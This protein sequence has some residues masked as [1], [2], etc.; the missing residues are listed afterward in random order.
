MTEIAQHD[1]PHQE[2]LS[3]DA[4]QDVIDLCLW[5]G[6]LLLQHGANSSRTEE[7][8][9]HFGTGLGLNWLDV[10]VMANAL[11]ITAVTE[12][13]FRTKTR[14]I[15]RFGGVNMAMV[16]AVSDLSHRVSAGELDRVAVRQ[17]LSQIDKQPRRYANWL[18]IVV[19]GL[20]CAA[21]SRLF[22]A[23]WITFGVTWVAAS[24]GTAVRQWLLRQHFNYMVQVLLAAFVAGS[25]ASIGT[26]QGWEAQ[27]QIALAACVLFLIPGVPL[28]NAFHDLISS[29]FITGIARGVFGGLI[30]LGIAVGL[31]LALTL[32]GITDLWAAFTPPATLWSD[33]LWA[34]MAA[35]GFAILFNLP[36]SALPGAV[37]CGAIGHGMRYV[38]LASGWRGVSNIEMASLLGATAVG[39]LGLVLARRRQMPRITFTVPGIIPMIPGTFA[40]G[41][42]LNVLQAAGIIHLTT[43]VVE[44][45]VLISASI[46]AI[47]TGLILAALAVGTVMP[48]LLFERSK[49]I[50]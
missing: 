39:F 11:T 10:V 49:P 1:A 21:F 36:Q 38:L 46:N 12:N 31:S 33:V 27:P 7:T 24:A 20:A 48:T 8:V 50:V 23:G 35:G 34:G 30:T 43:A 13:A 28:V 16:T 26:L 4:L 2:A 15:V 25:V 40:F 41:A 5:V 45:T 44:E 6:Q 19:V 32:F 29:Y 22:G 9:H 14:R 17:L 37:L 42:M 18:T 3:P 47:K